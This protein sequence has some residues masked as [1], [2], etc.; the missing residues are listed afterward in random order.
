MRETLTRAQA[1][2]PEFDRAA[3]KSASKLTHPKR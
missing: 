3:I 1:S 2:R